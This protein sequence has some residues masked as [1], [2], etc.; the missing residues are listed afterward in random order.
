MVKTCSVFGAPGPQSEAP[1]ISPPWPIIT[2]ASSL[3]DHIQ[4]RQIQPT[5][6]SQPELP[7]S[8]HTSLRVRSRGAEAG[9]FHATKHQFFKHV[10]LAKTANR[11]AKA[12]IGRLS[13]PGGNGGC[14]Q[15]RASVAPSRAG[16]VYGQCPA[17][18]NN[19]DPVG[20]KHCIMN[21]ANKIEEAH[22]RCQ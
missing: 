14:Q 2:A 8:A 22:P 11:A 16:R 12:T 4:D 15:G 3:I 9:G 1:S 13:V 19:V 18:T 6:E 17:G 21:L 10:L 20:V 5:E 7:D